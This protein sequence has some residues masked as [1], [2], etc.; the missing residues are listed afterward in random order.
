VEITDELV[1]IGLGANL[2]GADGR[3]PR[4]TCQAALDALV[5]AG[6]GV[7]RRS[8]WYASAPRPP[9]D[10]PWFVNAVAALDTEMDAASLLRLL[11]AVERQFGR[12]RRE[13]RERWAARVLDLDLLCHG[14]AVIDNTDG[15]LVLPH[16]RLHDR[17]FVLAP[18]AEIAP[19][20]RH[21]V[22]GRT[23]TTLLAACSSDQIARPLP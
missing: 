10:Q 2:P 19:G 14:R 6:V 16:P 4:D 9:S 20:W 21:P 3:A 7:A 13:R 17:A 1:L 23:A 15:G 11:L 12:E 18:L 22:S 5:D 8:R